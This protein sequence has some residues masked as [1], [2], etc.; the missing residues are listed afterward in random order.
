MSVTKFVDRLFQA[1]RELGVRV[2]RAMGRDALAQSTVGRWFTGAIPEVPTMAALSVVLGVR[3]GWL[4]F[5]EEPAREAAEVLI[6]G[7]NAPIGFH[8]SERL[9]D[10]PRDDTE[11]ETVAPPKKSLKSLT[12]QGKRPPHRRR[13]G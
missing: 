9:P 8:R 11:A 7:V 13:T 2:G 10:Y 1:H 5:G 6:P 3:A 4:A 12:H